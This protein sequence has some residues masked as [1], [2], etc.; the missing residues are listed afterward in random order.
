MPYY[1]TNNVNHHNQL[2]YLNDHLDSLG[3]GVG[4]LDSLL[5]IEWNRTIIY[6]P[7]TYKTRIAEDTLPKALTPPIV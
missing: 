7:N 3:S 4:L 5:S 2:L 6:T 1:A